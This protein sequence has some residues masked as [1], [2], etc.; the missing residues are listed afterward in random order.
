MCEVSHV[1][2]MSTWVP[3]GFSGFFP[4]LCNEKMFTFFSTIYEMKQ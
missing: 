3:S 4:K 2:L 1:L